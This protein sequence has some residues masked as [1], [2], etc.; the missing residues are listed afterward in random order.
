ML[1]YLFFPDDEIEPVARMIGNAVPPKLA[2]F[3]AG[4]LVNSL[5]RPDKPARRASS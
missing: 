2:E 4:Y 5:A 1:P 3:F